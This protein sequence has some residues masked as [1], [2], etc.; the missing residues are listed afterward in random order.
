MKERGSL[1]LSRISK[2]QTSNPNHWK[3]CRRHYK[4]GNYCFLLK[5]Y[6]KLWARTSQVVH[7][8]IFLGSF[9]LPTPMH[10]HT[11][12]SSL[13][14]SLSCRNLP[15]PQLDLTNLAD[16]WVCYIWQDF[17]IMTHF[18]PPLIYIDQWFWLKRKVYLTALH[19]CL[20]GEHM[21]R[22]FTS[23]TSQNHVIENASINKALLSGWDTKF[24]VN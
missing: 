23:T 7:V 18:F 13:K 4:T 14:T 2:A 10:M 5:S 1:R 9:N 15:S 16:V 24:V 17:W 21:E 12:T 11:C 22:F 8:S 19:R 3:V 6:F 20:T